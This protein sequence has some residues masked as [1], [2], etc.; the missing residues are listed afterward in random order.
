MTEEML[1][2]EE[3][4]QHPAWARLND[5]LEWYDH[6]SAANQKRYKQIQAAQIMRFEDGNWKLQG[7]VIQAGGV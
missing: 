6:K 4:R 3:V 5:Q 1:V 7:D 2:G